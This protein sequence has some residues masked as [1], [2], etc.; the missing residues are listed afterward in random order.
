MPVR[1]RFPPT[2]PRQQVDEYHVAQQVFLYPAGSGASNA[3]KDYQRPLL[4]L[5]TLVALRSS[6]RLRKSGLAADR[7]GGGAVTRDGIPC[8][9]WCGTL[10]AGATPAG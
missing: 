5:G 7:A 2:T 9:H 1:R 4:I 10:A 8:V 6:H 3:Q